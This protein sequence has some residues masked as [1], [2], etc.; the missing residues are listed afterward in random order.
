M[1]KIISIAALAALLGGCMPS[2]DHLTA[3]VVS[4]EPDWIKYLEN[5][6]TVGDV[7]FFSENLSATYAQKNGDIIGMAIVKR[8]DM[9][10]KLGDMYALNGISFTVLELDDK[11][12]FG[13]HYVNMRDKA[14]HEALKKAK[15]VKFYQFGGGILE[16]VVFSADSGAVCESFAAGKTLKA[17]AVTNY[18]DK[19]SA[20]NSEFFATLMD[21]GVKKGKS[22][23]IKN[24]DFKFFV[25]DGK[26]A[27]AQTR[28]R[29]A[30][31]RSEVIEADAKKQEQILS[32][33][34]CA[35]PKN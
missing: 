22:A 2:Q 30:D 26:L 19:E 1:K 4:P 17:H 25:S 29:S 34:V 28:A 15:T 21:I 7:A 23:E 13:Y 9:A 14:E 20:D 12:K 16:S 11:E 32:N 27:S 18:Y 24:L 8:A 31:F 6:G 33:I 3:N 10:L 35:A 5:D